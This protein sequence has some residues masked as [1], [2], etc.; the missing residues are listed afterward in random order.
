MIS[1]DA[2]VFGNRNVLLFKLST[3]KGDMSVSMILYAGELEANVS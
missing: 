1:L 3:L 2:N